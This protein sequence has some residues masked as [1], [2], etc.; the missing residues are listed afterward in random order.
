MAVGLIAVYSGPLAGQ[1]SGNVL[2][3]VVGDTSLGKR[4][5]NKLQGLV[6]SPIASRRAVMI[7]FKQLGSQALLFRNKN[8]AITT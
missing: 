4:A 3:Y 5:A 1:A 7:P 6:L 2:S 8:T